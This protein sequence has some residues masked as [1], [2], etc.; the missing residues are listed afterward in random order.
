MGVFAKNGFENLAERAKLGRYVLDK[1]TSSGVQDLSVGERLRISFEELGP[2][3]IKLGQLLATRPDLVPLS[4]AKEFQK[5]HDQVKSVDFDKVAPVI[6]AHFGSS[7]DQIFLDFNKEP[8]GAASIAQVYQAKLH[9]GED[10][11]VKV[12]RPGIVDI[13]YDDLN[14]LYAL[15]ELIEKYIPEARVFNPSGIVD[16]FFKT[17]EL[18]TNFIVEANNIRRFEK[19]FADRDNIAIPKVY[20]QFSGKKVLVMEKLNGILMS[21]ENAL[22]QENIDPSK[23][24]RAGIDCYFQMVFKDGFFHGDMHPGNMFVLP[25]NKLGLI[26][27]GVV[28]R[29]NS[30]TQSAIANMFMAL[31]TEDYDRFAYEYVDLAPYSDKVDVDRL[32]RQIRDTLSPYHGLTLENVNSGKLLLNTTNLAAQN[33][34]KLPSELIL[35]FKSIITIEGMGRRVKKDFDVLEYAMEFSL[36]LVQ[37]KYDGKKVL[38]DL[39]MVTRDVHGLV[40]AVPRHLKHLLRRWSS[41]NYIAKIKIDE[42]SEFKRVLSKSANLIFLGMIISIMILSS[43]IIFTFTEHTGFDFTVPVMAAFGYGAAFVLGIVAFIN[44]IRR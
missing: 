2:T 21:Q 5:L 41:P 35:F 13:I 3:F 39:T 32:S 42:L 25:D 16:E 43:T 27:F 15:A 9:T 44:Y 36:E 23:L 38:K 1:F 28:G 17:L 30:K 18:E 29:L 4:V 26:D 33:G 31:A 14:V 7:F 40:S 20:T 12:L 10:V 19:N 6:E 34:L 11:V 22:D 24:I 37:N 8:I